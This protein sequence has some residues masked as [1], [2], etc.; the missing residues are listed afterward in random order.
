MISAYGFCIVV[1]ISHTFRYEITSLKNAHKIPEEES[2]LLFFWK[3]IGLTSV[4]VL[5]QCLA[6]CKGCLKRQIFS[7]P[8][9]CWPLV[10]SQ[11]VVAAVFTVLV[12]YTHQ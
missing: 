9:I 6:A 12:S 7:P 2:E 4:G 5:P 11:A 10:H 8:G 3:A 1:G